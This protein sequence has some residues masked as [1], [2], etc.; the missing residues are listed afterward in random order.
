MELTAEQLS[1][2][3]AV[4]TARLKRTVRIHQVLDP[5]LIGGAIVR[6]GDLVFD[7]SLRGRVERLGAAL[8]RA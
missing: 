5:S 4:L 1:K 2:L 7:G 3:N 8:A 6:H